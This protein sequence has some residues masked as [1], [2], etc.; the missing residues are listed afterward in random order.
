MSEAWGG[1]GGRR[2]KG[3]ESV[4]EGRGRGRA[5]V[6]GNL[7]KEQRGGERTRKEKREGEGNEYWREK[8]VRRKHNELVH[9][10][11]LV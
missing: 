9:I 8:G 6:G 1:E 11:T 5:K 7:R 2:V 10:T 4:R 3:G